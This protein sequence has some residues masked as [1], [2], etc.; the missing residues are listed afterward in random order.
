MQQTHYSQ[1]FDVVDPVFYSQQPQYQQHR[2][3]R[4]Q[5]EQHLQQYMT[6]QQL[7][8]E[9]IRQVQQ[10]AAIQQQRA[11]EMMYYQQEMLHQNPQNHQMDTLLL[12]N[13]HLNEFMT[14]QI[15]HY[16]P[17][18]SASPPSHSM[19]HFPNQQDGVNNTTGGNRAQK[20][21]EHNAIER[22]RRECL[23]TKFQQL[24]HSLPNLQNDRRPSKG[25]IIER[26]L[27]YVKQT[28]QKEERFQSEIDQLRQANE[29][30]IYKM[31]SDHFGT[32]SIIEE[33]DEELEY[34]DSNTPDCDD[35][36]SSRS[37][38][39]SVSS[40][41]MYSFTEQRQPQDTFEKAGDS[42]FINSGSP[43]LL[44]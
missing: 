28:V 29:N 38:V 33:A 17:S 9:R 16:S 39:T 6:L 11:L 19:S 15:G 34:E 40:H 7:E 35:N 1:T 12:S 2:Q 43:A 24:A 20:R 22:A 4:Q 10:Q 14:P 3:P 5:Q 26:T 32:D 31:T 18:S 37:S 44:L 23:N 36:F 13:E 42:S 8:L 30:L 27:E 41:H 21:A 25:T